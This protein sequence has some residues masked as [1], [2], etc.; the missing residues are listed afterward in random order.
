MVNERVTGLSDPELDRKR[1][2]LA[3]QTLLLPHSLVG[4]FFHADEARK[5]QGIV[6]ANPEPGFYLVEC[7]EWGF[8]HPCWQQIVHIQE[9]KGWRFYD[10]SEWM[11][12]RQESAEKNWARCGQP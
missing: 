2:P 12:D 9:M 11:I 1:G 8:G 6:V 7:F 3:E 10:S 4:S 5:W